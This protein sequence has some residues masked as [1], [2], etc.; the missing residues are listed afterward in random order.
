MLHVSCI[1]YVS[2]FRRLKGNLCLEECLI[3]FTR[4]RSPLTKGVNLPCYSSWKFS[5]SFVNH[6]SQFQSGYAII[7]GVVIFDQWCAVDAVAAPTKSFCGANHNL[8]AAT[9]STRANEDATNSEF[10]FA[11]L[12]LQ[13]TRK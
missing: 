7:A 13:Q 12:Q 4:G 9:L 5:P 3:Y 6:I 1:P 10:P 8:A 2:L 11:Y